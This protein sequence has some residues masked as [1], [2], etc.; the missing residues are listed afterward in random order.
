MD[1]TIWWMSPGVTAKKNRILAAVGVL[2]GLYLLAQILGTVGIVISVANPE[3]P[4]RIL[5]WLRGMKENSVT[6]VAAA[7]IVIYVIVGTVYGLLVRVI[8][9]KKLNVE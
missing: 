6:F 4:E 2:F 1:I 9:R 3:I 5:E 7:L 8:M